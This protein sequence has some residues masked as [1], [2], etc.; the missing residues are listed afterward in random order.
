MSYVIMII[1]VGSKVNKMYG[2]YMRKYIYLFGIIYSFLT[3]MVGWNHMQD[4]GFETFNVGMMAFTPFIAFVLGY[5][6]V[7]QMDLRD[8]EDS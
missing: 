7:R 4:N 8:E 5:D 2:E 1:Q 6:W 3:F